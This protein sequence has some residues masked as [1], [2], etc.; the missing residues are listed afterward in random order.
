MTIALPARLSAVAVWAACLVAPLGVIAAAG[1]A[2]LSAPPAAASA[3]DLAVA[4]HREGEAD[5]ETSITLAELAAMPQ[6][7]VR[8]VTPWTEGVVEF[9]GVAFADLAARV[10]ASGGPVAL[11]ALNAYQ[12]TLDAGQI[13]ADGGVLAM[14]MDGKPMSVRDKGPLWLVFPSEARPELAATDNT[15]MWIWQVNAIAFGPR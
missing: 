7:R 9:E 6:T 8:A 13:I 1:V 3:L 2:A 4:V 14:K 12:I 5:A 10:G 11:T 15:H